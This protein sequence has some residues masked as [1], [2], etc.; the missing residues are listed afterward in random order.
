M[1]TSREVGK[2]AAAAPPAESPFTV[3]VDTREQCPYRFESIVADVREDPLRRPIAI[4]YVRRFLPQGDYSIVGH[5]SAI[6]IERKSITDLFGTLGQGRRRF[7]AELA[8]L[9]SDAKFAAVVVEAEWSEILSSPPAWSK[10][11]PKTVYRSIL[12]WQQRFPRVHWMM[13][14]GRVA[15]EITTYRILERFWIESQKKTRVIALSQTQG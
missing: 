1:A 5:E 2:R 14:P 7:E 11:S 8:R 3:V 13:V 6:A 4:P 15:G 12:A 9:Q 10:L